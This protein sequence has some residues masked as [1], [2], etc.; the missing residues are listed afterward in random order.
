MINTYLQIRRMEIPVPRAGLTRYHIAEEI[1]EE[2]EGIVECWANIFGTCGLEAYGGI[3]TACLTVDVCR[4]KII[5]NTL[6]LS[7]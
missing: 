4:Y 3:D 5:C 2:R 7:T 6:G 1:A